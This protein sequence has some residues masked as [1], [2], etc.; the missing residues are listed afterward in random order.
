MAAACPHPPGHRPL[1]LPG[2]SALFP[3]EPPPC[4]GSREHTIRLSPEPL[5]LPAPCPTP[6]PPCGLFSV[7]LQVGSPELRAEFT[8]LLLTRIHKVGRAKRLCW[9]E[10][11]PPN[12]TS[13]PEPQTDL[14]WKSGHHGCN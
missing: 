1:R 12:F 13:F 4:S 14:I 5:L 3:L 10:S 6:P 7:S 8:R 11:C 2:H 9:V